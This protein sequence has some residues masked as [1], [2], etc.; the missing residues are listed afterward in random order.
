MEI[1]K[2]PLR[3]HHGEKIMMPK[4]A[5]I[6]HM[7]LQQNVPCLWVMVDPD[8]SYKEGRLIYQYPTG[9]EIAQPDTSIYLG[10]YQLTNG[11]V[12]HV[13]EVK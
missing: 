13:F 4:G 9:S 12:G 8:E 10:T 3:L 2:Y 11:Y 6:L 5:R 7:A 1:W